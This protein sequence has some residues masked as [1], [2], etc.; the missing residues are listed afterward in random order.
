MFSNA[1]GSIDGGNPADQLNLCYFYE[2]LLKLFEAIERADQL[3][4]KR[5]GN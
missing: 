2:C 4:K 1:M 5:E 3:I